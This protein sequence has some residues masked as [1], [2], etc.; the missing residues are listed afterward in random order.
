MVEVIEVVV[1]VGLFVG[2]VIGFEGWWVDYVWGVGLFF[3]VF[4]FFLGGFLCVGYEGFVVG[5]FGG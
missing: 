4:W 2:F 5:V 1:V 3:V